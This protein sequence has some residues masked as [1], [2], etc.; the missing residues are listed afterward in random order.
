[1]NVLEILACVLV[2]SYLVAA[3]FALVRNWELGNHGLRRTEA[4]DTARVA[5]EALAWP[6]EES[7]LR[8]Q[9]YFSQEWA[10][11]VPRYQEVA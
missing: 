10:A 5:W 6:A 7:W 4:R 2:A 1:M 9:Q 11:A 8:L 3:S